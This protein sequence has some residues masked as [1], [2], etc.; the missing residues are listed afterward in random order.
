[1][2]YATRLIQFP[3]GLV[4][5]ATSFAVLPL[6]S[7]HASALATAREAGESNQEAAEDTARR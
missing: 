1:M 4:G 5:T 2:N 7:K 6:L 3:L